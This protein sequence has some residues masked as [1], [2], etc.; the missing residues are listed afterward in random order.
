MAVEIKVTVNN[1]ER[2]Q[3]TK[4]LCYEEVKASLEDPIIDAYVKEAL[5]KF[6]EQHDKISVSMLLL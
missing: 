4:I 5:K 6:Q 2:K 1:E 3:V